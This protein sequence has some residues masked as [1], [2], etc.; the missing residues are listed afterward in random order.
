MNSD[1]AAALAI[2]TAALAAAFLC[3]LAW[4]ALALG[5]AQQ[6]R[7]RAQDGRLLDRWLAELLENPRHALLILT[8]QR[9]LFSAVALAS[10]SYLV[11]S[12]GAVTWA[13]LA[14]GMLGLLILLKAVPHLAYQTTRRT[15]PN[16]LARIT[17]PW[18]HPLVRISR[19]AVTLAHWSGRLLLRPTAEAPNGENG[20]S[21]QILIPVDEDVNPP[22][23]RELWMI[24]AILH[25]EQSTAREIMVPRMDLVALSVEEPLSRATE[26]MV[27]SGHRRVLVYDQT[28]DQPLGILH[29][30]DLLPLVG[31]PN[32]Q[33]TLREL[34]RP[35][36]FIPETKRLDE[37][38]PEFL[39]QGNHITVL[40]D[41]Y[42]GTAGL[43]TL[44][45]L[46]EEILGEIV[47]EFQHEEPEVQIISENEVELEARVNLDYLQEHFGVQVD[48]DGF[49]TVGGLVYSQLGRI[50][51]PG[52]EVTSGALRLQVVTTAGKR[53]KRVRVVKLTE[54]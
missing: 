28:I 49:D 48:R 9:Y 13:S 35:V 33:V 10:F 45:D 7:S 37:L 46:L 51:N 47:D 19:P 31:Q 17:A 4:S 36:T 44:E 32:P 5:D 22:D 8:A 21:P 38:L 39:R 18:V 27:A 2:L 29:V 12:D 3:S 50:P 25:L 24:R 40:V 20:A 15:S 30:R 43:V 41:E 53:I 16:T 1:D 14:G 23:E 11:A 42:G 34:L 26:L 6:A 54:A 52:D